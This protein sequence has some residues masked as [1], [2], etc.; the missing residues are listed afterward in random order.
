MI[1][2]SGLYFKSWMDL[3]YQN[4]LKNLVL[5]LILFTYNIIIQYKKILNIVL[6]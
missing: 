4:L 1:C 6:N 3:K 2:I 5:I